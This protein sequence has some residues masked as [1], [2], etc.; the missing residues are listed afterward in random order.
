MG[1]K[2]TLANWETV[3]VSFLASP[4]DLHV[5]LASLFTDTKLGTSRVRFSFPGS[6]RWCS[7]RSA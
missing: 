2:R 3:P 5:W 1:L 4:T 7:R 6:C